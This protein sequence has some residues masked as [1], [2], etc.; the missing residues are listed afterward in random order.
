[1]ITALHSAPWFINGYFLS[2]RQ[3]EPNFVAGKAKQIHT[4]IWVRLPQLSTE[5]YD[6]LILR[7]IGNSIGKLLKIDAC[8]S[9]TLRGRYVRL[10]VELPLDQ[11]VQQCILIGSYLQN[12]VYEGINFLCKSCGYLGHTVTSCT[13]TTPKINNLQVPIAQEQGKEDQSLTTVPSP[14][15]QWQVVSFTRRRNPRPRDPVEVYKALNDPNSS[16]INASRNI[17]KGI[18]PTKKEDVLMPAYKEDVKMP[19]YNKFDS[20]NTFDCSNSSTGTPKTSSKFEHNLPLCPKLPVDPTNKST[21]ME[22]SS[23]LDPCNLNPN[24]L[25][26]SNPSSYTHNTLLLSN[27]LEY[28]QHLAMDAGQMATQNF[29]PI[30]NSPP[31]NLPYPHCMQDLHL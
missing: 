2:T 12:L 8:T 15:E 3:W 23:I 7:K 17:K 25:D 4:T 1:M 18:P 28:T 30:T 26:N 27:P 19:T 9:S 6:G 22:T 13:V 20:L 21:H 31:L 14:E 24:P 5:F 16:T 29:P 11:P 10:C